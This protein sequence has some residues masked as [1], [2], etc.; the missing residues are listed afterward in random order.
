MLTPE[1]KTNLIL[2]EIGIKRYSLRPKSTDLPEKNYNF[3][4][5]GNVLAIIDKPFVNFVK[6]QQDLIKA[7]LS[8][9]RFD[10]GEEFFEESAFHSQKELDERLMNT[11]DLKLVIFFGK[12][13]CNLSFNC[14]SIVSP[15]INQLMHKQSLKKELWKTIKNKLNL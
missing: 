4:Q 7:I 9:T 10:D 15:S 12:A 14:E 11:E 3:Y 8:S 1:I 6:E 13:S 2:K 5:K